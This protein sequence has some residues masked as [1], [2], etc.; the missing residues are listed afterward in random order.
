MPEE[1]EAS[2]EDFARMAASLRGQDIPTKAEAE[3]ALVDSIHPPDEA[4]SDEELTDEQ[5]EFVNRLL[6]PK[7]DDAP[8]V[9]ALHPDE[10]GD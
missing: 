3:A 1:R 9:R 10:E 2:P 6:G 7:R 8:M 5:I 4:E